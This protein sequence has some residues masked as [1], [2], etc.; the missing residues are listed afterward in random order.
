MLNLEYSN[1]ALT[2]DG[3]VQRTESSFD[4]ILRED[5]GKVTKSLDDA[6]KNLNKLKKPFDNINN[7]IGDK[8]SDYSK[9]IDDKGKLGIKLVF[10][11]LMIMNIALAVIV[12]FIGLCSMKSCKDCCFCRCLFKFCTHLLWN[13]L[14]LLMILSFIIGSILSLVGRIGGDAME[15]VSYTLSEENLNNNEDPFLIGQAKD[16]KNYL[17][18]CLHGNGSLESEFDLGDSLQSIED[19]DEVLNGLDDVNQEFNR[20]KT[21]LP[22]FQILNGKIS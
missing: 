20:I 13:I 11:V 7:Q 19:I 22:T 10:G 12:A 17:K 8:I 9:Q 2:T 15:L 6:K 21:N 18:I 16:V 4:K 5:I 3:Y 14:A 1:V